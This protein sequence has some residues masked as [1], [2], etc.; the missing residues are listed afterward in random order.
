[1]KIRKVKKVWIHILIWVVV[2]ILVF[3]AMKNISFSET[4][5]ILTRFPKFC[6]GTKNC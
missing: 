4:I 6:P 3:W 1:M 2:A 5:D